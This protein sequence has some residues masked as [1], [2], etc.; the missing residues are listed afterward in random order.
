ML[1][2]STVGGAIQILAVIVVVII[3]FTC[4]MKIPEL[5][6][7][8]GCIV[9]ASVILISLHIV[10]KPCSL[11]YLYKLRLLL[12]IVITA[13]SLLFLFVWTGSLKQNLLID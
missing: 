9:L 2:F 5:I 3:E 7:V 10:Q 6:V 13:S 1:P 8:L 12:L 4:V 11:N